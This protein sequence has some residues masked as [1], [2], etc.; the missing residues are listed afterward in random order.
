[1]DEQIID[2]LV[3][4]TIKISKLEKTMTFFAFMNQSIKTYKL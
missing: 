3:N 2:L 4:K 1:M